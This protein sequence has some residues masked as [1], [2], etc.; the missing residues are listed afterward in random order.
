M[1]NSQRSSSTGN[2]VHPSRDHA[3]SA[4]SSM[5]NLASQRQAFPQFADLDMDSF[6]PSSDMPHLD[7]MQGSFHRTNSSPSCAL[8]SRASDPLPWDNYI[9]DPSYSSMDHTAS[10][11]TVTPIDLLL[12]TP[13]TFQP[14]PDSDNFDSPGPLYSNDVSPCFVVQESP[15]DY[16]LN[17]DAHAAPQNMFPDLPGTDVQAPSTKPATIDDTQLPLVK[18]AAVMSRKASGQSPG[19][20]PRGS[21]PSLASGV[22]K[23][24]P[25]KRQGRLK[26][27]VVNEDDPASSK[28]CRNTLAA[29]N[30]RARRQHR[31]EAVERQSVKWKQRCYALG[32]QGED[33]DEVEVE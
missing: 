21:R 1:A 28:R 33:D 17:F 22:K 2:T 26:E 27:M 20:S 7:T 29:R 31:L 8:T 6:P 15:A 10:P 24:K 25:K 23:A 16:S 12:S 30:S 3:Y 32:F 19:K 11:A 14:T 9:F 5:V 18:S 4:P 13:S